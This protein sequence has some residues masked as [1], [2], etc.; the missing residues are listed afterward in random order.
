[1][2]GKAL[3][4]TINDGCAWI[5][6]STATVKKIDLEVRHVCET[7]DYMSHYFRFFLDLDWR[8]A[9]GL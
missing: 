2:Q 7:F 3:D 5:A 9:T 1:L 4:I 8:V 6:E